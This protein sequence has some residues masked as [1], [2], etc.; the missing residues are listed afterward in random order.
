MLS[1]TYK[2]FGHLLISDEGGLH[3][4]NII[5]SKVYVLQST[6]GMPALKNID[7]L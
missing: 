3:T 7:G 4:M 5:I 1:K 6:V 2:Q